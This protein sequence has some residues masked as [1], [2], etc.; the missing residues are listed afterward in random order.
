MRTATCPYLP[1]LPRSRACR[2]SQPSPSPPS[3]SLR[4]PR[5]GTQAH[6]GVRTSA[7]AP[8]AVRL[9][10]HQPVQV[11]TTMRAPVR[12]TAVQRAEHALLVAWEDPHLHVRSLPLR[13][14]SRVVL[15]PIVPIPSIDLREPP[16]TTYKSGFTQ[17]VNFSR[18]TYIWPDDRAGASCTFRSMRRA[19]TGRR[20][21]RQGACRLA[22]GAPGRMRVRPAGIEPAACGLKDRQTPAG[23]RRLGPARWP[24]HGFD[25]RL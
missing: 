2:D 7:G 18:V 22:A 1:A 5:A 15:D 13:A 17:V 4:A 25:R 20:P 3:P 11:V 19:R 21:E 10:A 8:L 24:Q 6:Q 16:R 14:R 23:S 12:P 9:N